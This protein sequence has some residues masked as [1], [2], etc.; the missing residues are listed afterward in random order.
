MTPE[1]RTQIIGASIVIA[2]IIVGLV[3]V[4]GF[5]VLG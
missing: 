3:L 4:L 5:D 1:T 2:L